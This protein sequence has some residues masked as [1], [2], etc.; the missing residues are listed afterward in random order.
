MLGC[1]VG[2]EPAESQHRHHGCHVDDVAFLGAGEDP[3]DVGP[4]AVDH[5]PQVDVDESAPLVEGQFPAEAPIDYPGI[6]HCD[7]QSAEL[8]DGNGGGTLDI[9]RLR[10]IG[11]DRMNVGT[12]ALEVLFMAPK[13]L[14]VS[15]GHEDPHPL[16]DEGLDDGEADP[17]CRPGYHG[18]PT[19]ESLHSFILPGWLAVGQQPLKAQG[20]RPQIAKR[21]RPMG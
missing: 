20:V 16:G 19:L 6:V 10:H 14:L 8:L 1:G 9:L 12:P 7:M 5:A 13:A 17:A 21:V 2:T 3:G 11:Q 15:I 4:D 18:C